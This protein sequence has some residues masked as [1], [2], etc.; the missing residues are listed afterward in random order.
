MLHV[1]VCPRGR[2]VLIDGLH[3]DCTVFAVLERW[4]RTN[5]LQIQ[6][7]IQLAL[8]HHLDESLLRSVSPRAA[9]YSRAKAVGAEGE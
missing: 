1:R 2:F 8:C 4:A 3:L 9:A 6:D 7:A 5:G